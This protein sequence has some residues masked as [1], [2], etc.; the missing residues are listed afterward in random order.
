[1]KKKLSPEVIQLIQMLQSDNN[2]DIERY[3]TYLAD[4]ICVILEY[5]EE[6][7]EIVESEMQIVYHLRG[8]RDILQLLKG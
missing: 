7:K 5:H 8:L 1:M 2:D 6:M 4:A 3:R